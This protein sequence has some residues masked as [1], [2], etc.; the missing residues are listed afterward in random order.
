MHSQEFILENK[1]RAVL[2]G[3]WDTRRLPNLGQTNSPS[4]RQKKKSKKKRICRIGDFA[5]PADQSKNKR[6]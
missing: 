5:V 1:T 6:K 4:D 3:F 2:S